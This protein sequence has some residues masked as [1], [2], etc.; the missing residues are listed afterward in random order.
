MRTD[1]IA[2]VASEQYV[3]VPVGPAPRIHSDSDGG[4]VTGG[5]FHMDAHNGHLTGETLRP[6]T[7][8]I[9]PFFQK[10]LKF[11]RSLIGIVAA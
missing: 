5:I 9:D 6:Q 4:W 10:L 8:F 7:Y 11:C 1:D 2:Q 3:S